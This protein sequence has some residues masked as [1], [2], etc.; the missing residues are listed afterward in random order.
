MF[1]ARAT[2]EPEMG[3][4]A[5]RLGQAAFLTLRLVDLLLPGQSG[6]APDVFLYQASATERYARE[7]DLDSPEKAHLLAVIK[8]ARD[9]FTVEQTTIAVPALFAYGHYLEETSHYEE[10]LDVLRALVD[11]GREKLATRDAIATTLRIARVLR[12][13]ARFDEAYASYEEAGSLALVSG[14]VYSELLSR[15]GRVTILWN[16]GNLA[17][18]EVGYRQLIDDAH[19]AGQP[20]AEARALDGLASTLGLRGRAAEAIPNAWRAFELYEDRSARVR[21]LIAMGIMLRDL[22]DLDA[23]ERALR[24]SLAQG[25]GTE[26]SENAVLEL[27]ECASQR[28][29][30]FGYAR[31]RDEARRRESRFMPSMRV[32]FFLKQGVAEGRF[33]NPGRAEEHLNTALEIAQKFKLHEYVFRLEG[34]KQNLRESD[35]LQPVEPAEVVNSESLDA[36]RASLRELV[37]V[38]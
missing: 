26:H 13:L 10:A 18:A 36:V 3:A 7:M 22:G 1:L 35:R 20:D 19:A 25:N 28:G 4:P 21:V 15:L 5:A 32:D 14:D 38:D 2:S 27:M 6:T 34:L 30:R 16:R 9:A 8:G 37:A 29:D 23:A 11:L 31:W 33:G 12:K 17:E 24:A